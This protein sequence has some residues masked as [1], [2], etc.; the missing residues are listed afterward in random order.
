MRLQDLELDIVS[1]DDG[2]WIGD[3]PDQPGVSFKVRGT[4]YAP[5]QKALRAA[6]MVQ[7]RRQRLQS[8]VDPE[9]FAA[10]QN[11]LTAEHLLMDWKGIE[12][13]DGTPITYDAPSALKW[14]TERRY[15]PFQRGVMH[16]V[17]VVDAGLAEHREEASGN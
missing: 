10:L 17:E 12:A 9:R 1:T 11:R 2:A 7:G 3:I 15:R 4:E 16:A 8:Q 6:L 13:D 5:Y 14:M